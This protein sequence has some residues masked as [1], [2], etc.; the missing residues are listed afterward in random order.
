MEASYV[1]L[2][3]PRH[4]EFAYLRRMRDLAE[5]V[6][7]RRCVV[8][9][10][11]VGGGGC[12]L[13]RC[14]SSRRRFRSEVFEVDPDV[15]AIARRH[16]GLRSSPRLRLC[17][18]DARQLL[19]AKPAGSAD[20]VLGDAFLDGL[21]PAHLSSVEFLHDVDRVLG[22][23]GVYAVNIV[24]APPLHRTRRLAAT[25]RAA[26]PHVILLAPARVLHGRR[27][28]NVVLAGSAAALPVDRLR[29]RAAHDP[30]PSEVLAGTAVAAFAAGAAVLTDAEVRPPRCAPGG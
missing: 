7:A 22:P 25:L 24:D 30:E 4:I 3:D 17:I 5:A 29:R 23:G 21:V 27:L 19:S 26:F 28:G 15:V 1:D 12:T 16:L 13:A 9:V 11:H 2:A 10:I 14:L 20:L 18:G 8:R 6:A